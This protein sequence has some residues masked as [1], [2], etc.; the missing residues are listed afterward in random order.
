MSEQPLTVVP[1]QQ[2]SIALILQGAIQGGITP[3]NVEVLERMMGLYER[4]QA[5]S[6]QKAFARAFAQLQ[7]DIP[8]IQASKVVLNNDGSARYKFAPYEEIMAKVQPLLAKHGFSITFTTDSGEERTKVTCTLMH[9]DGHSRTNEFSCRYSKPPGSSDT[10]GDG[11]TVTYAK[12]YALCNALN[13]VIEHDDDARAL[14]APISQEQADSLKTRV[15]AIN[16]NR[17]KFLALAKSKSFEE[18]PSSKYAELDRLLSKREKEAA[19]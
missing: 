11:S 3:D 7:A 1:Q 6:A 17:D 8:G 18:I 15:E 14:G 2:P 4:D 19:R 13:I 5:A 9:S 10:Q 12:R 16:A